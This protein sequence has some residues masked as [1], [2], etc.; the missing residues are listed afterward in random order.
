MGEVYL[1]WDSELEH[2]VALKVLPPDV[3]SNI[4]P[5]MSGARL[6]SGIFVDS[7]PPLE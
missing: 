4:V 2:R 3:A 6:A 5:H 1:A 7:R